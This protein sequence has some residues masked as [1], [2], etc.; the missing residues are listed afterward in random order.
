MRA[1]FAGEEVSHD[2]H[3]IVD[4]A[5]LWTLPETPPPLLCAAVSE[6]TARWGGEWADG[7]ATVNA[8]VE[9]LRRML[10]AFGADGRKVLQVHLSLGADRRGGAADRVRPVAHERLRPADLLGPRHARGVRRRRA[11]SCGPR[12]CARRCS[13]PPTSRSTS[14]GCRSSRRSGFDDIALHHVGQ[15]LD[16]FIDAFGEHVLPA[17]AMS[18]KATSDLWWK[19]AIFYCLDVETFLDSDGDG[20]GDLL[21]L[22]ERVDYL[23][24]L[25]ISCLWLMPFYPSPNRD[26]GYDIVDFFTVDPAL[27]HARRLHRAG[28][29][30]PRPRHPRDRRLRHEPHVRPAPVVPGRALE[31]RLAVP[32]LLRLARREAGGEARRRRLPRPGDVELGVRPQGRAVLPAQVLLA[33]ARPQPGQ[34]GGPRRARAGDGASGCSRGCRASASTRC[35]S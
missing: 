17:A 5:R 22:T 10:D 1:L 12:T 7:L 18:V 24:G 34:P 13:S 32:R 3:V 2:G 16:A 20:C 9:H 6:A 35:R 8:P 30:L 15:D 11:R 14:R 26:D 19:D 29:H 25:G 23:A 28:P 21:G 33:P 31:P 4:R 27:R